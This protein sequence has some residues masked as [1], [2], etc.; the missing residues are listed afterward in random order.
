MSQA[1][2]LAV[3]DSSFDEHVTRATAPVLL[4]FE[5]QWCGPCQAMKPTLEELAQEYAGK[6]TVAT[7]DVDQNG[8]TPHRCGVRGI[9]TL[10]LFKNGQVVAQKVGLA[11]KPDL[12]S[13]ID[14]RI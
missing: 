7:L 3:T 8:N 5:A 12:V 14:G 4:K 11:R 9:P 13:L 1:N 2:I 6:L 10:L